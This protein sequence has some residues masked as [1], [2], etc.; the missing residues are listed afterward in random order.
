MRTEN[1]PSNPT[2]SAGRSKFKVV[3]WLLIAT[4]A[5]IVLIFVAV[6]LYLSSESGKSM[7]VGRINDAVDGKVEM[8][9]L[10]MG[11]FKGVRLKDLSFADD[12][13]T[14]TVSVKEISTRPRY[15]ALLFGS[16]A[17]GQTIID[18]PDIVITVDR[19]AAGWGQEDISISGERLQREA[20]SAAK[21]EDA[22]GWGLT[23][24]DLEVKQGTVTI[25]LIS[26]RK[27]VQSVHFRNIASKLE[28]SP[29]PKRSSFDVSLAVAGGGRLSKITASGSLTPAK[30]KS[31]TLK[32]TSG[33]MKIKID[34]LDL[35]S[36]TPLFALA[37]KDIEA[38]G[39][40]SADV[41]I[42]LEDGRFE[43]VDATAVLTGFKQ[44]VDGKEMVLDE[45][46]RV[47]AS[48][49]ADNDTVK[50]DKLNIRS[51]FCT[52]ES[53]GGVNR[54]DYTATADLKKTQDFAGQF[55]DFGDYAFAGK[56][57][58]TGTISFDGAKISAIGEAVFDNLVI[59]KGKTATPRTAAKMEFDIEMDRDKEVI[60]IRSVKSS[61]DAGTV[62][63]TKS[64]I[65]LGDG[66]AEKLQLTILADV[67]LLR[68]RPYI[69]LFKELPE[70]VTIAG[71]LKS[72]LSIRGEKNT[73]RIATDATKISNLNISKPGQKPFTDKLINISADVIINTE[74]K[75]IEIKNLRIKGTQIDIT[76]DFSQTSRSGRTRVNGRLDADFDL[77]A[78]SA[79]AGA[80]MPEGL[81]MEGRR[82]STIKFDSEYA[83]GQT[84]G[85]LANL[86]AQANFG[87]DRAGYM[88]L[89][90]GPTDMSLKVNK[91]LLSIAPFST[92]V[93]SG[94][95]N[96]AADADFN[97]KPS[98]L[99]TPKPMQI[100]DKVRITEEMGRKLLL[101]LNPMFANQA[102]LSGVSNFHCEKMLIPLAG[103][104]KKDIEVVGTV[105]I[106][107]LRLQTMGL[108]DM[109]F[110]NQGDFKLE[111][112]SFVLRDG[113]LRYDDM[114]FNVGDNPVNFSGSVDIEKENYDLSIMLPY[115]S[116]GRTVH[117]GD[118]SDRRL[119]VRI[120]GNLR[121]GI[122][123]DKVFEGIIGKVIQGQAE[124]ILQ[125]KLG[126]VLGEEGMRLLK[127]IFK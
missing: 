71:K 89:D 31:W 61:I 43:K 105:W 90:F 122:N 98:L 119:T 115:T 6:P 20:E 2:A 14:I 121:N 73:L 112:S 58:E 21:A 56:V 82:K 120:R 84:G 13:G 118:Q 96:F 72:D 26:D 113:L 110:S 54:L 69:E 16:V 111:K 41:D 126:D 86:N 18:R 57:R 70:D 83:D 94:K 123:W 87:F 108:P 35:E 32:G 53:T 91:G 25:N 39:K 7:I 68:V 51:S 76:G 116:D 102:S 8:E 63:I 19:D 48:I 106:D 49:S 60:R 44:I 124:K 1:N 93:N 3:K 50:I 85:L 66:A 114:Q 22:S 81:T 55:I 27:T 23:E 4:T 65:P 62:D 88:G 117:V 33:D 9:S 28:L 92:T 77:A 97:K 125:D 47:E 109:I 40:L 17:L 10:S 15:G 100:L 36:L 11:W 79:I 30:E 75:S 99:A 46:V 127:D 78:A 34:S 59:K 5:V 52:V 29:A 103:G 74:E 107:D 80:F 104:T 95:L 45:P 67:D 24:L 42:R 37:G 64:V 101:Y 12:K 38:G